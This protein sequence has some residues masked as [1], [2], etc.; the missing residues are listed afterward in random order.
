M[1]S[2]TPKRVEIPSVQEKLEEK[3]LLLDLPSKV[4]VKIFKKLPITDVN[5]SVK[6]V[7]QRFND[8]VEDNFEA[9]DTVNWNL[10]KHW[11]GLGWLKLIR[12]ASLHSAIIDNLKIQGESISTDMSLWKILDYFGG[13]ISSLTLEGFANE[14]TS[15]EWF[16]F[17]LI[18]TIPTMIHLE[19]FAWDSTYDRTILQALQSLPKLKTIVV[20]QCDGEKLMD[21]LIN[22]STDWKVAL[23]IKEYV[24]LFKYSFAER[25]FLDN[26]I[27]SRIVNVTTLTTPTY[28]DSDFWQFVSKLASVQELQILDLSKK[29]IQLFYDWQRK[30]HLPSSGPPKTLQQIQKLDIRSWNSEDNL[31]FCKD[32]DFWLSFANVSILYLYSCRTLQSCCYRSKP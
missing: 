9:I 14:W 6:H 25:C 13:T 10:A 1:A 8:I 4:I 27:T 24:C 28:M 23:N 15:N 3:M 32:W 2:C 21:L 19:T 20:Y 31:G 30:R 17:K 16:S 22:M 5:R 7:C 29:T 26:D 18:T 12:Y 11:R